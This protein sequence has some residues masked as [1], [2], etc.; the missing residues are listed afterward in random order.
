MIGTIT[1]V[2]TRSGEAPVASAAST[3]SRG[4]RRSPAR[5]VRKTSGA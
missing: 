5:R 4:R 3:K 1:V 2:T